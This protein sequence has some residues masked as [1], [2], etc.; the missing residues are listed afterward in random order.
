MNKQEILQAIAASV[1][2]K[3]PWRISQE[4]Y[5]SLF[6]QLPREFLEE[7]AAYDGLLEKSKN[8]KMCQL[9][10]S[11]VKVEVKLN[12]D[13][14]IEWELSLDKWEDA[15]VHDIRPID[16]KKLLKQRKEQ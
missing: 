5:L 7:R 15:K 3:H 2:Q 12:L 9:V 10:L 13:E 14:L 4:K 1:D 6:G 11:Q 16:I 8:F